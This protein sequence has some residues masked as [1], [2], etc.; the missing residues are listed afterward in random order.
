MYI[1]IQTMPHT[2]MYCTCIKYDEL[3]DREPQ[4]GFKNLSYNQLIKFEIKKGATK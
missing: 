2:Y 1:K 4:H 3:V